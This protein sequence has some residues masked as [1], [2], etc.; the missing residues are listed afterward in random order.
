MRERGDRCRGR[1]GGRVGEEKDGRREG[2]RGKRRMGGGRR[3]GEEEGGGYYM[4]LLLRILQLHVPCG[5]VFR[6]R[7]AW[8]NPPEVLPPSY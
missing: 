3:E 6:P 2:G 7:V 4:Y 8:R 5:Q 1:G